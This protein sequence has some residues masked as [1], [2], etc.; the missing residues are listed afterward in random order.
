MN[1]DDTSMFQGL[2]T[3]NMLGEIDALPR[4]LE[5]AWQ[6][7]TSS[8][9]PAW[10]G[11]RRVIVAGMGGSAI[12]A[13]LLSAY[14]AAHSPVPIAVHRDYSLPAWAQ[15]PETLVITSSHSGNTEET[16]SAFQQAKASGCRILAIATG[17]SLEQ[18]AR[19]ASAPVWQFQHSGQPRAAVGYSFGLLLAALSRLGLLLDPGRVAGEFQ[20]ALEAMRRQQA[21]LK[22]DVPAVQNPAKRYAG[23]LIG[24]FVVIF[25]AE[26]LAPV[27]RR[28]KG[29]I[30]EVAKAMAAFEVIPEAN[31]NTLAGSM[32][33]EELKGKSALIFLNAAAYNERNRRRMEL[34]RKALM[35]EGF[36]TDFVE[37]Q[38][39]TSLA[40]QWT[41]LNFGD[42]VSY[43]LAMAYGVDPTPIEALVAFKQEMSKG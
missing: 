7:G 30:N 1:L 41:A 5:N 10:E 33:P 29:Q 42:Y 15:G 40:Q 26:I 37:A 13:D 20:S 34:T 35:L 8:P 6:I 2:D 16:L 14:A 28:W 25:G 24:R 36:T 31:H 19:K 32:N 22:A 39:E 18:E 23:Q 12:G 38:G 4:Q 9:L 21:Q 27:A 11:I 3:Q 43:Y 17:G